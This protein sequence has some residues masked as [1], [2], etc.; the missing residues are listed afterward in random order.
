MVGYARTF[1]SARMI[2]RHITL[3]RYLFSAR[4]LCF[5]PIAAATSADW[6]NPT[7]LRRGCEIVYLTMGLSLLLHTTFEFMRH[8]SKAP[9]ISSTLCKVWIEIIARLASSHDGRY[10]DAGGYSLV[11]GVSAPTG[12]VVIPAVHTP[13]AIYAV[14]ARA[15]QSGQNQHEQ[16]QPQSTASDGLAPM[17]PKGRC[18]R[19][20][21]GPGCFHLVGGI[22]ED[23][24]S[25]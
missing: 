7:N 5:G 2:G 19:Q 16:R 3:C 24:K 4:Y 25:F 23:V 6:H 11:L 10:R 12:T 1:C 21:W 9:T 22:R 13:Q 8:D 17:R 14:A 15:E 20:R 18:R